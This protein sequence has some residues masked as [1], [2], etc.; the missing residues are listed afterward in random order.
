LLVSLA[1]GHN[2]PVHRLF[3]FCGTGTMALKFPRTLAR[4]GLAAAIAA[5]ATFSTAQAED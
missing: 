4:T 3:V 2:G 5:A 1:T